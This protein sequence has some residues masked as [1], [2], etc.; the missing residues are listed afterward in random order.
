MAVGVRVRVRVW[1]R[2]RV[3]VRIRIRAFGVQRGGSRWYY[4]GRMDEKT[5][6]SI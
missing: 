4:S 3:R 1:A 6:P 5:E 2:V